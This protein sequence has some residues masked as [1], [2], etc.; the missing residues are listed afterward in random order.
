[1]LEVAGLEASTGIISTAF[2]KDPMDPTWSEDRGVKDWREF[3]AMYAPGSDIRD[4]NYVFGYNFAMALEHVLK[5]A[6][7]DLSPENI[8][9]Q[10]YSIRDLE[11]PM[12]LPSIKVNTTPDDHIPVKQMQF[13]RFDGKRWERFGEILTAN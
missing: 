7:N 12:L 2:A 5:A 11:L 6:G 1:V 9:K 3:M 13:M 10:A 8:Y 4:Q